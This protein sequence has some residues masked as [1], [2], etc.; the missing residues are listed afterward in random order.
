[1]MVA[2]S[3]QKC[4]PWHCRRAGHI[5]PKPAF[6]LP[7]RTFE[8]SVLSYVTVIL[9]TTPYDERLFDTLGQRAKSFRPDMK[10]IN[11]HLRRRNKT[12]IACRRIK[13]LAVLITDKLDRIRYI[14]TFDNSFRMISAFA[15]AICRLFV[16]IQVN[17]ILAVC[18]V[19][20]QCSNRLDEFV[21]H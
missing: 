1:M 21:L 2:Q 12:D 17:L 4:R 19:I 7:R 9:R 20:E 6:R 15:S 13:L 16:R 18:R 10:R 5:F 14:G 11:G 8:F 3:S